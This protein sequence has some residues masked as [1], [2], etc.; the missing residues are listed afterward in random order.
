MRGL[1]VSRRERL[2]DQLFLLLLTQ[3]LLEG[4]R[5]KPGRILHVT[6]GRLPD[7]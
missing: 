4:V 6:I 7:Q 3:C 2:R 5:V 1:R